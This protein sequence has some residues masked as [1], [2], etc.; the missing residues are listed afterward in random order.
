MRSHQNKTKNRLKLLEH[1]LTWIQWTQMSKQVL[2]LPH[3][4]ISAAEMQS[5][6]MAS[7]GTLWGRE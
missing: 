6:G 3:N 4:F 7:A 2:M 5:L 1:L